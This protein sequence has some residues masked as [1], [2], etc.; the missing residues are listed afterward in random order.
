M[1]EVRF[2][3]NSE[4]TKK[5]RDDVQSFVN[6][7]QNSFEEASIYRVSQAAGP[8]ADYVKALLQLG[9]TYDQIKPYED[10]LRVCFCPHLGSR[11]EA[12]LLPREAP[13]H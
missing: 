12:G 5:V 8:I 7:N 6:K 9:N 4:I 3:S 11:R 2:G 1:L 10:Q 13:E